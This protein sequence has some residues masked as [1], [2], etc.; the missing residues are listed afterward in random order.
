MTP[1]RDTLPSGIPTRRPYGVRPSS[2][3]QIY[4]TADLKGLEPVGNS[5]DRQKPIE[6]PAKPKCA[7]HVSTC[8]QAKYEAGDPLKSL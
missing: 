3:V 7:S 4:I 5:A 6:N 1:A 2:P 8:Y